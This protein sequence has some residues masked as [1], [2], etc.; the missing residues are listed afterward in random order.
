MTITANKIAKLYSK[1]SN[2]ESKRLFFDVE[3]VDWTNAAFSKENGGDPI[4]KAVWNI[5]KKNFW[6][7]DKH[8]VSRD[9]DN[10]NR[11]TPAWKTCVAR[12]FAGL[13]R[14]DTV[15]SLVGVPNIIPHSLT[16][17]EPHCYIGFDFMES[18]HAQSYS[19][20]FQ[21]F[22]SPEEIAAVNEWAKSHPSLSKKL[23]I[24]ERVYRS[25]DPALIRAASVFFESFMFWTS[26]FLPLYMDTIPDKRLQVTATII[27]LIMRDEGIHGYYIGYKFQKQLEAYA[28]YVSS[29]YEKTLKELKE[30]YY[31]EVLKLFLEIYEIEYEYTVDL[32]GDVGLVV[33]VNKFLC[34]NA[35]KAFQ[36]LGYMTP[37]FNE[38][39][40]SPNA[41][42]L[43]LMAGNTTDDIF[44]GE[45]ASYKI[46]P[47]GNEEDCHWNL[48]KQSFEDKRIIKPPFPKNV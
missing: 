6:D 31:N 35:N 43:A 44:S 21:T 11:L 2:E 1:K 19:R 4:D 29:S 34:Y 45:Q 25:G 17:H 3:P 14:L 36:N 27:K 16:P 26:F 47:Y 13:T 42:V 30:Y 41:S 7:P 9:L 24:F 37:L 10:W 28:K 20:I 23:A 32:Y 15:Q 33:D 18:I 5:T 22:L 46:L 12:V 39:Q 8:M 48:V 40:A 38:E